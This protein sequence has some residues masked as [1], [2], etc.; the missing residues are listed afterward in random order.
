MMSDE[1]IYRSS[2]YM[3]NQNVL[4]SPNR[5]IFEKYLVIGGGP[6]ALGLMIK[7]FNSKK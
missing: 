1:K 2:S 5:I 4:I 7:I 3:S 6:A